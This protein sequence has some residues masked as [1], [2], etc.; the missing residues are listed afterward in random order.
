[1]KVI[2]RYIFGRAFVLFLGAF[3]A[4][5]A[6]VWITQ[7][8]TRIN[9]ITT[10]GQSVLAFLQISALTLPSI[11]PE[12]LPFA[13]A[14]A[15]AQTLVTMNGDSELAVINA[16]G[17]PRSAVIRPILFLALVASL[18]SF[19][20][21][22]VLDPYARLQFRKLI[23]AARADLI[24]VVLQ[25]AT[26]REVEK[27]VYIQIAER[28]AGGD[29][30]GVFVADSR[31]PGVDLVYYAKHGALVHDQDKKLLMMRDGVIQRET[32]DGEVSVIHF[33]TYAFD[34]S[35]FG[36]SGLGIK[37]Q[38]RDQ[39][40]AFLFDPDPADPVFR[41]L[42]AEFRA[43]LHRRLAE[44]SLPLVF[45]LIGLAAAGDARSHREKRVNPLITALATAAVVR[46]LAFI[47]ASAAEWSAVF[48]LAVY[49]V[50]LI[51]AAVAIGFISTSRT[52]EL[53]MAPVD[54]LSSV[55]S[56]A[57]ARVGDRLKPSGETA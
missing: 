43:E 28:F 8:L 25:E 2:E 33:N 12:V 50:P 52:F 46:W 26:F 3:S 14:I 54:W 38:P 49:A 39:T 37:L 5:L 45:A 24:S 47:A 40:L 10:N 9:L 29:L 34:L 36:A 57:G 51:A 30:G 1:M 42:P 56:R 13:V 21:T 35:P 18:L 48:I 7:A 6:I 15:V 11:V 4:S 16:A 22:N 27:G 32:P 19:A 23:G 17:S 55:A 53:P 31:Q 20:V 41:K 44:W